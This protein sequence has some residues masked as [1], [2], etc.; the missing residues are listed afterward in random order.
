M[1]TCAVAAQAAR[2]VRILDAGALIALDRGDRDTWA[3]IADAQRR[4]LRPAVPAPIIAQAWRGGARQAR[5]A[6]ALSGTEQLAADSALAF[7]AGAL[8]ALAGTEDVL[9]ALVALAAADRPGWEVLTSDPDD[10]HHLLQSLDVER[11]VR[12][13]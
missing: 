6:R 4:G 8:L 5:L 10:I 2:C 12:R 9:D 7:R 3:L 13:V 11:V 1:E